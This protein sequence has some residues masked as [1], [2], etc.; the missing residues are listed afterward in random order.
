M[1]S[2]EKWYTFPLAQDLTCAI[3]TLLPFLI[4]VII[5]KRFHN[6]ITGF[7]VRNAGMD[8]PSGL[9]VLDV[10]LLPL[11][12]LFLAHDRLDDPVIQLS[13]LR[14]PLQFNGLARDG[15]SSA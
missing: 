2:P 14:E 11:I 12:R 1:V 8:K 4:T 10:D 13:V 3:S 7:F 5:L 6:I 15:V 9:C